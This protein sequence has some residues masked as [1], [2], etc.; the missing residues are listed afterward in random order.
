MS[1]TRSPAHIAIAAC[2]AFVLALAFPAGAHVTGNA[3]HN[4][5]KHYLKQAKKAFFTEAELRTPG[6]VNAPGNPVDWT[7]LAR[8]PAGFADG[9]DGT[10]V[11]AGDLAGSDPGSDQV[12]WDNLGGVPGGFADG[13]DASFGMPVVRWG[14]DTAAPGTTL[15]YPGIAFG[16][17]Y[18][19]PGADELCVAGGDPG[20]S[21]GAALGDPMYP[22][23]TAT[24][25]PGITA[26]KLVRCAVLLPNGPSFL[27]WGS[28]TAPAGWT[29]AYKGYSMAGHYTHAGTA[30]RHCVDGDD[31]DAGTAAAVTSMLWYGSHVQFSPSIDYTAETWLK[32]S[33]WVM[34]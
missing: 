9:V 18:T 24:S 21:T 26:D 20:A 2:A 8:V 32:C 19:H 31:F 5:T 6:V 28:W 29:L 25:P 33:L 10:G 3:N 4:W 30:E 11:Q 22:V 17:H 34:S 16:S 12:H 7:K 23:N 27:L 15:L 14:N 1:S 13:S